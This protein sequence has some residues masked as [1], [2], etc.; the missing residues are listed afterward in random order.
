MVTSQKIL[1]IIISIATRMSDL[2][3]ALLFPHTA[4]CQAITSRLM[5][6]NVPT[7]MFLSLQK[8]PIQVKTKNNFP[9]L[10]RHLISG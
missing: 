3:N 1:I 9:L 6:Q 5:C 4:H 7:D 10:T 8:S 2:T